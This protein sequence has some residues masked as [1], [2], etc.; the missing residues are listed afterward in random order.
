MG[1]RNLIC[2]FYRGRFV[3]AQ[4]SQWDGYPEGQGMTILNFLLNSQNIERLKQGLQYIVILDDEDL[5]Q[6]QQPGMGGPAHTNCKCCGKGD[7]DVPPFPP[8]LSRDTG[9]KILEMVAQ[10][11][12]ETRVPISLN[13]EFAND[14][15]FCEWA[16]VVDLDNEAFEVFSGGAPKGKA[17][18]ERFANVGG[19]KETVPMLVK[20]FPFTELPTT[21][22]EFVNILN[23]II[24]SEKLGGYEEDE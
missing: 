12:P 1:T 15:G 7:A 11:T 23:G 14:D 16:Y 8:S 4:Y 13:L 9:A 20:S 6:Y 3:I 21:Q 2:V 17:R 18:S 10:A 22:D 24:R 5:E 19:E